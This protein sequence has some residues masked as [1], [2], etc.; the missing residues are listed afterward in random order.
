MADGGIKNEGLSSNTISSI[1]S[2]LKRIFEYADKQ[3]KI[4]MDYFKRLGVKQNFAPI[5]ILTISEQKKLNNYLINNLTPCNLGILMSMYLGLRIGE[6]CALK[7]CD[8]SF[9]EHIVSVNKTMQRLQTDENGT[10]KTKVIITKPKSLSSDRKIPIPDNIYSLLI[11]M[12]HCD[13][14]FLLTGEEDKYLEPRTMQNKFKTVLQICKIDNV[15]FHTL[16]HTFATRC[17]ELGFD[18]KS[19]SEILGHSNVNITLNKYVHPSM[20]LKQKNMNMLQFF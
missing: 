14:T 3:L 15:N 6:L 13:N 9:D 8:I 19:L 11:N 16:R 5:K 10:V 17:V 12:E 1:I 4:N 7:W 2:V 18:I 20:T